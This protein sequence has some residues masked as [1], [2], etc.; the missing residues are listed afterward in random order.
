[1]GWSNQEI[2]W[3]KLLHLHFTKL[4]ATGEYFT[5][6]EALEVWLML[7]ALKGNIHNF[8]FMC[9]FNLT[10]FP[11]SFLVW[12]HFLPTI[13]WSL[14]NSMSMSSRPRRIEYMHENLDMCTY[15]GTC[16]LLDL[17]EYK[18]IWVP[19]MGKR[20]LTVQREQQE[21]E[22][23]RTY[24]S[25]VEARGH[26]AHTLCFKSYFHHINSLNPD[27]MLCKQSPLGGGKVEIWSGIW[28]SGPCSQDGLSFVKWGEK[29]QRWRVGQVLKSMQRS[30]RIYNS[31][32][33]GDVSAW[34][35]IKQRTRESQ[36]DIICV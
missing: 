15:T 32:R 27:H 13:Y 17:K 6:E 36:N 30:E 23:N 28:G 33:R 21:G 19:S 8:I 16:V 10:M 9:S 11:K 18:R 31:M 29:N 4:T 25:G 3:D 35:K 24:S 20:R 5:K 2:Q 1:M 12:A 7:Y 34:K 26:K 14:F 22:G